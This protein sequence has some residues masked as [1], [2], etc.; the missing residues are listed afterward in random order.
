MLICPVF[1]AVYSAESAV[2]G[3][4]LTVD[5]CGL[6]LPE[7][8]VFGTI[9]TLPVL[10]KL[11][12]FHGPST[13]DHSGLVAYV[14]AMFA[15]ALMKVKTALHLAQPS[16]ALSVRQP[17]LPAVA[18]RLVTSQASGIGLSSPSWL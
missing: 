8:F 2:Y 7:Y 6:G 12:S 4:N 11:V 13:T 15:W 5:S 18:P 14:E 1:S 17:P 3:R 10:L 9:V 16:A